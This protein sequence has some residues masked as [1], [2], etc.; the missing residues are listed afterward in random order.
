[1]NGYRKVIDVSVPWAKPCQRAQ[2]YWTPACNEATRTTRRLRRVYTASQ[3]SEDWTAYLKS[4]DKKQKIIQKAKKLDFRKVVARATNDPRLLWQM[5]KW[6]KNKSQE[7]KEL[8]KMPKLRKNGVVAETFQEKVHMFKEEFFPP[9][10]EADLSD[11]P[12]M[13]YPTAKHCPMRIE[14]DE[15]MTTLRKQKVNKASGPDG[16]TN[17]I[18]KACAE[19]V[20][21]LATPLFQACIELG[22]HPEA[23]RKATT[24]VLKKSG[25]DDYCVPK[26][27]RPIALLNTMGKIMES[28]MA[29]RISHLA[30]E[31]SMLPVT[32]MGA[33]KG[34][35]T[36]S[37]LELLTEQVH[38]V[39]GQGADKVAT[40]LSMDVAGAFNTVSHERLISNLRK[41]RIPEWMTKWVASFL[42][43]RVTTLAIHGE[44]SSQF[45][46]QTGIPQGSPLSPIL[47]LFYNADL[48]EIT[49]RAGVAA[50]SLGFVDD[51]NILAYGKS[52]EGNCR[53]LE[54]M[55][56]K[57]MKWASRHGSVFA[58]TKYELIHLSRRPKKF[59]MQA[60]LTIETNA[61]T[62][63]PDIRILGLQIDT[64][65]RWG[66]H[67][68]KI[69]DKMIR[70][71]MALSKITASTWGA[72][73]AKARQVYTTVIRPAITYGSIAWH[74]PEAI[75]KGKYTSQKL[76]VTQNKCLRM[77]SGAFRATPIP[78]LEAETFVPPLNLH[79][80]HLQAK[81][82]ARLRNSGQEKIVN[83]ECANVVQRLR[84]TSGRFRNQ[85]PTPGMLKRDWMM[86]QLKEPCVVRGPAAA[87]PW[88]KYT[89][90]DI[91]KRRQASARQKSQLQSL[92][93]KFMNDWAAAWTAYQVKVAEPTPA[94]ES[95]L[96][97]KRLKIHAGLAKAE[98]ALAVQV[99]T[100]K[101]GL[102]D[103]LHR[104]KV[105]GIESPACPC[106]AP[107][108]TPEHVILECGLHEG[109]P[110]LLTR[111]NA[112]SYRE[113]TGSAKALRVMTEWLMKTGVLTQFTL[114]AVQLYSLSEND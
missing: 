32:Q 84:A 80:D 57:C 106:G 70:Q 78:V 30:E 107:R 10:P 67:V 86:T 46:V 91:E 43:D 79:L 112:N 55:H 12:T 89:P 97:R 34:R 81:A 6:G 14:R 27:Y 9:P 101:I 108:Q 2:S 74:I 62:P 83:K 90:A 69:Q 51:V 24:V 59:N 104:R 60:T 45:K 21:D 53:T 38:T 11:I 75:Q 92:R 87:A 49:N 33:R 65:L 58:P 68:R 54:N 17:V 109:R 50:S 36:E 85:R 23:Y 3:A 110:A 56:E 111:V 96:D 47:Y 99:R 7:P 25:K 41:R 29:K 93:T 77:I 48:L 82:R 113:I 22:Y 28:I 15:V 76:T 37:A 71:T 26:S 95:P 19:D 8:P 42:K 102:A 66:P 20:A 103:F 44:I 13:R 72:T 61:V 88:S 1:M 5:A 52:T 94:Q 64:K 105:P 4:N 35:S 63:K 98:S 100:G 31:H 40:L 73:F 16:V 39:W 18:L 114:A